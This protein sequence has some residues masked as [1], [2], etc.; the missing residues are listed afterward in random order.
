MHVSYVHL[1][2]FKLLS[3]HYTQPYCSLCPQSV[4]VMTI[5]V[6][7][8]SRVHTAATHMTNVFSK[9]Q[10]QFCCELRYTPYKY[11]HWNIWSL[12]CTCLTSILVMPQGTL[13]SK[14][15]SLPVCGLSHMTKHVIQRN[16]YLLYNGLSNIVC[17]HRVYEPCLYHNSYVWLDV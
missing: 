10:F 7:Y 5:C 6:V 12:L 14:G 11:L 1:T 8:E 15:I 13:V 4:L 9:Q 2:V 17:C 16:S 3:P